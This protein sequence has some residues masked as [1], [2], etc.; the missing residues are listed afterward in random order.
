MAEVTSRDDAARAFDEQHSPLVEALAA[1][2]EAAIRDEW[3][4]G[5]M[6]RVNPNEILETGAFETELGPAEDRAL[7]VAAAARAAAALYR[8]KGWDARYETGSRDADW[9]VVG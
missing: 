2:V 7:R 1:A 4:P 9:L 3:V 6:V 8:Q 5:G